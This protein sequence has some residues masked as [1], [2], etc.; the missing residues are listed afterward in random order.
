[1]RNEGWLHVSDEERV[2]ASSRVLEIPV[3][4]VERRQ[5]EM[6]A[7]RQ[8]EEEER[9]KSEVHDRAWMERWPNFCT[10]CGGWGIFN[11]FGLVPYGSTFASMPDIEDCEALDENRCHR[12]G[13]EGLTEEGAGPC[14]KCGWNRNDGL[15]RH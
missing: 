1:M 9:R 7:E 12:C 3:E 11:G 4:E 5:L 13:E 14:E 2:G 8:F 10:A 6:E 15:W